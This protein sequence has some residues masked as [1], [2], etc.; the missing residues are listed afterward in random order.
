MKCPLT[1]LPF[2]I[3]LKKSFSVD[4]SRVDECVD[5]I[6]EYL[7]GLGPFHVDTDGFEL[8]QGIIWLR[9]KENERLKAIHTHLVEL[10]KE[11]FGSEP[12]EFDLVFKYHATVFTDSED[13]LRLAFD[14]VKGFPLPSSLLARDFLVGTSETGLPGEYS[15]LKHSHLGPSVSVKEQWEKFE[16]Q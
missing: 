1:F 4:D 9:V 12:H 3:S 6:C 15:V 7:S 5:R 8:N 2:H 10:A 13:K 14:E 16:S 11:D